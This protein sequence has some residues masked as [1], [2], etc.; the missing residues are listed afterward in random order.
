MYE[1]D[2]SVS[3]SVDHNGSIVSLSVDVGEAINDQLDD[4]VLTPSWKTAGLT[5]D[6]Q[7]AV[8]AK[9]QSAIVQKMR[10]FEAQF[11]EYRP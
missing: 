10:D 8:L 1:W 2:F 11:R 9:L 3:A 6:V 5:R 7:K 4:I